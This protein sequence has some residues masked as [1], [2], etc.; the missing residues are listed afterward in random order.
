M[1]ER[2]SDTPEQTDERQ[3]KPY[4]PPRIEESGRYESMVLDCGFTMGAECLMLGGERST[5]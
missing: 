3:R 2:H 5:N 4:S 1:N